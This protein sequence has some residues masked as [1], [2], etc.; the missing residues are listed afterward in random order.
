LSV[1]SSVLQWKSLVQEVLV[2]YPILEVAEPLSI[3]WSE[4]DGN[5]Q[6][7]NLNDPSWGLMQL[8]ASIARMYAGIASPPVRLVTPGI[9]PLWGYDGNHII[10]DPKTNV[11]GGCG[12]LA[13]LKSEFSTDFPLTDPNCAWPAAYNE[14]EGNEIKHRPD[15]AYVAA[16]VSHY[17]ELTVVLNPPDSSDDATD[18]GDA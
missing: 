6:A 9:A 11:T 15:P 5:P 17:N 4:S 8:T 18:E 3:I 1:P 2:A 13:R 10:F 16:F 14:G 7:V 12:F